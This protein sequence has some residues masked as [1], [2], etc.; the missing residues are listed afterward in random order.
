MKPWMTHSVGCGPSAWRQCCACTMLFAAS[1]LH[2]VRIAG[3]IARKLLGN[4]MLS[5]VPCAVHSASRLAGRDDTRGSSVGA[6]ND[7][8]GSRS[9]ARAA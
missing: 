1:A 4:E 8:A 9:A 2:R 3:L 5:T 6:G 7:F